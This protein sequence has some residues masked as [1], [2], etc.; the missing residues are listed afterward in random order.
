MTETHSPVKLYFFG[1]G[2]TGVATIFMSATPDLVSTIFLY[3]LS[4]LF[5]GFAGPANMKVLAES[6]KSN[7]MARDIT[8]SGLGSGI[9]MMAGSIMSGVIA[10]V[11]GFRPLFIIAGT[12]YSTCAL[13]FLLGI[14]GYK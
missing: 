7:D 5:W 6:A 12:L 2:L 10:H 9:G 4:G 8:L 3:I 13:I 14:R 11:A 1:A